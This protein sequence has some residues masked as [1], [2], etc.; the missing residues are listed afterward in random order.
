MNL[1]RKMRSRSPEEE[2]NPYWMSFSDIMA[3]ILIIFIL[4]CCALVLRLSSMEQKMKENIIR[5][6]SMEEEIK[7]NV[8]ALK[9]ALSER[10]K[11]LEELKKLLREQGFHVD[12]EYDSLIVPITTLDFESGSYRISGKNKEAAEALGRALRDVLMKDD[13]WTRLDTVFVEG[14]TDSVPADNRY[15]M[16][17]WELSALRAISLWK[18]WTEENAA[19]FGADLKAMGREY[20]HE[21]LTNRA[22]LFSVSGYADTR[23]REMEDITEEQRRLNRRINIRFVTKQI[24]PEQ[25][26]EISS[27]LKLLRGGGYDRH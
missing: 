3:G 1:F 27:P 25:L 17:N 10:D 2:E 22:A 26:E 8:E 4:V 15:R 21:G 24:L 16:G 6:T 11:M 19:L 12:V 18:F 20:V 14:H 9:S 23:R 7:T 13:R 5:L